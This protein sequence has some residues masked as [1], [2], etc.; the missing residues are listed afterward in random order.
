MKNNLLFVI[1]M[2]ASVLL[3]RAGMVTVAA[4]PPPPLQQQNQNTAASGSSDPTGS[5]ITPGLKVGLVERSSEGSLTLKNISESGKT[6]ALVSAQSKIYGKNAQV[7][8]AANVRVDDKVFL[9]TGNDAQTTAGSGVTTV[10]TVRMYVKAAGDL[11]LS[12]RRAVL[13]TV[14]SVTD[15]SVMLTHPGNPSQKYIIVTTPQTAYRGSGDSTRQRSDIATGMKIG[16]LGDLI[17]G[18]AI[19]AKL[20]HVSGAMVTTETKSGFPVRSTGSGMP[21]TSG[22]PTPT[23]TAVNIIIV[24]TATPGTA[25]TAIVTQGTLVP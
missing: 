15:T 24:H 7:L 21:Q 18:G 11:T 1:L 4:A 23:T 6:E 3:I 17:T 13:G 10:N 9:I 22:T 19:S 2:L 8:T 14:D 25:P 16:V 20:I 12:N 5:S